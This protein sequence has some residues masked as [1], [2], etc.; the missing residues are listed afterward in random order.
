MEPGRVW[1]TFQAGPIPSTTGQPGAGGSALTQREHAGADQQQAAQCQPACSA[2]SVNG[3]GHRLLNRGSSV[4]HRVF[5]LGTPE[6]AQLPGAVLRDVR[7]GDS[8]QGTGDPRGPPTG[9][10]QTGH[11]AM[12]GQRC[13]DGHEESDVGRAPVVSL[14][15]VGTS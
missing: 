3:G 2:H 12:R 11:D 5:G 9:V 15:F 1:H 14:A 8:E 10:S 13:S 6:H 7:A 4:D